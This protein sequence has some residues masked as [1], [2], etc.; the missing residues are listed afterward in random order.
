MSDYAVP[1][2]RRS[3]K[4]LKRKRKMR[5]YKRGGTFRGMQFKRDD[6]ENSQSQNK[7]S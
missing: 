4:D 7:S 1:Y 3:K 6:S 5:V 2:Q